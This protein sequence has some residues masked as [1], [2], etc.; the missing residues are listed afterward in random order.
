MI[1]PL[2]GVKTNSIHDL[3][4]HFY[5]VG[6]GMYCWVSIVLLQVHIAVVQDFRCQWSVTKR[7]MFYCVGNSPYIMELNAKVIQKCIR[8]CN[9]AI[10]TSVYAGLSCF[11]NYTSIMRGRVL[12][13]RFVAIRWLEQD[14]VLSWTTTTRSPCKESRGQDGC[15][16]KT[17]KPRLP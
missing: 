7:L 14:G 5:Y 2:N 10:L 13:G 9:H 4:P 17:K 16:L 15:R 8:W 1:C 6:T 12:E 3:W 11:L